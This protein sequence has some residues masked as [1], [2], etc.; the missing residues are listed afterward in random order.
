MK[1]NKKNAPV[2]PEGWPVFFAHR[3]AST[4]APEN[5]LAAFIKAKELGAKGIELDVRLCKTGE[6]VV[7]H[8]RWLDRVAGIH[9]RVEDLT[10]AELCEIDVGSFFNRLY[11]DLANPA[12]SKERIPTLEMVFEAVGRDIFFDIELKTAKPFDHS[13]GIAVSLCLK[14]HSRI[15]CIISSFDPL[16]L[17][18]YRK[19]G[20]ETTAIIYGPYKSIPFF[21]RH[22]EG[23]FLSGAAIKKPAW[24]TVLYSQYHERGRRPVLTWTVD[25]RETAGQLFACGA[26]SVITNRIQDFIVPEE[27]TQENK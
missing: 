19:Y 14:R 24:E 8:D 21:F 1:R 5:T 20:K 18:S 10:Y 11:P 22:R 4:L 6:I 7:T 2:L 23:L 3:G 25:S 27:N 9:R 12:F 15:N 16:S 17:I 13:L 26:R